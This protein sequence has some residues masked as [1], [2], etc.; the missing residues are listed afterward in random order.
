M[1]AEKLQLP[2]SNQFIYLPSQT[3]QNKAVTIM[4]KNYIDGEKEHTELVSS[5]LKLI[6]SKIG[7]L[8]ELKPNANN[9]KNIYTD[10]T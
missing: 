10:I 4:I 3:S 1:C 2:Y 5:S 8:A 9:H 6:A 7:K